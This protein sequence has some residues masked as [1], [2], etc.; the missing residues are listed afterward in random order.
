MPKWGETLR[1]HFPVEEESLKR[2]VAKAGRDSRHRQR[3]EAIVA[4]GHLN[5]L[6]QEDLKSA[7]EDCGLDPDSFFNESGELCVE[8][9][10]EAD[11]LY[12]LNED[13]YR[14]L[15]TGDQ[16]RADKKASV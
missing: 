13:L 2:L 8:E 10:G 14:G 11:L 7:M 15:I 6:N 16:F 1:E 3:L 5:D 4:R 9:G 12:F